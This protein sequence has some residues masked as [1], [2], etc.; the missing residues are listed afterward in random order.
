MRRANRWVAAACVAVLAVMTGAAFAAVP[1]YRIFCQT[2]G[3]SGAVP[4]ATH[5]ASQ[6][7]AQQVTVHFDTNVR[8]LPWRFT[9]EQTQQAVH[10]GATGLAFFTVTNTSDKALTGRAVYNVAPLQVGGYVR[11]L[12]CFCFNDQTIA[13]HAT[14]RFPVVYFIRPEFAQ[15]PDTRGD[16]DL[17][18]SYTF[19]PVENASAAATN[20]NTG[21]GA[22]AGAKL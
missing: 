6:V 14:V 12:Q 22:L 11:K 15:D 13:A 10:V 9:P 19:Y 17:T 18:L 16:T 3:F 1:L 7:L 20:P 2:T 8:Q 5:G 4:R 21:A